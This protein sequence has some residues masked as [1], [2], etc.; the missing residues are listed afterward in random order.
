MKIPDLKVNTATPEENIMHKAETRHPAAVAPEHRKLTAMQAARL[1]VLANVAASELRGLT[2]AQASERLKWV[3][4]PAFFWFRKI[5]GQV[6]KPDPITGVEYPVPY[7]TVNVQETDCDLLGYFPVGSPWGW[8]FPLFCRR[9]TIATVQTDQCGHFCVWVPRFEFEWILRWRE[10]RICYET[11]FNRPSLGDLLPQPAPVIPPLPDPGPL[12]SFAALPPSTVAAK[13]GETLARRIARL[14]GSQTLGAANRLTGDLLSRRAFA[15]ELP[16]PLPTEF[17][18]ALGGH[19][20]VVAATGASAV[21]GIRAAVALKLGLDPAAPTL[22]HF[23][24]GRYLGP[25]LRCIDILLPEWQVILEVPDI[26]FLVTQDVDGNG[27]RQTIYDDPFGTNWNVNPTP[28]VTLVASSIAKETRTCQT[29]Q[30]PCGNTPAILFAG[31]MPLDNPSYY[32]TATGCVLRPNRPANGDGSVTP[33]ASDL[34]R[35]LAQTPFCETL[36]LYGCVNVS[37]G[38]VDAQY[39]RVMQSVDGGVT[40]SAITGLSWNIYTFPGGV[41][42][43]IVP[44]ANGWYAVLPD[45]DAFH[46]ARMVLEWP[47]PALGLYTLKLQVGDGTKNVIGES[48]TVPFQVDN[49]AP[50]PHFTTLSWKFAGAPDSSL[51]S[52]LG[53]PCPI[54]HRG[55]VPQD[56]EVVFTVNVMANHLRD[57]SIA[58]SGCGGGSFVL[59]TSVPGTETSHWYTAA[60]DNNVILTG[61]YSL[62]ASASDGCYSFGCDANSRAMNPSGADGGNLV[63]PDWYEDVIYIYVDPAINVAV[64]SE[65]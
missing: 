42:V 38:G 59:E 40:F 11:I 36:Q 52:L 48:A 37:I 61:R 16:P 8:H 41:P 45:P 9:E 6:V 50:T 56:I 53:I 27:V 24:P 23:D 14:Q 58:V 3:I 54:I 43:T 49:T 28:D 5:C 32:D 15:T 35:P 39:Y 34:T 12:R 51:V 65:N 25:F 62:S 18:H 7:A 2:I 26:T 30:V 47:T 64:V 13:A 60:T 31:L 46:P 63:P 10:V 1:G 19:G 55:A 33:V 21:D 29:P 4:D 44:D 17:H 20:R 22:A 57:A